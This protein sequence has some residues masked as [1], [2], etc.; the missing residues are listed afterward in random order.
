MKPL[1]ALD[2]LNKLDKICRFVSFLE[3]KFMQDTNLSSKIKIAK[4]NFTIALV[5]LAVQLNNKIQND[6]LTINAQDLVNIEISNGIKNLEIFF[7]EEK[8]KNYQLLQQDL[9]S[10]SS[11]LNDYK[12]SDNF[13]I[14][15]KEI[16]AL[17][18]KILIILAERFG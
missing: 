7:S 4:E 5:Q 13:I 15:N 18:E 11:F 14:K 6:F 10:I 9:Q 8:V 3:I 16:A 1:P 2:N 17:K 12:N